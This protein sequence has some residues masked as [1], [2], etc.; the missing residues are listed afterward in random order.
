PLVRGEPAHFPALLEPIL[1][2]PFWLAGD[3]ELAYRLTQGL[4]ALAMSL[5]AVPV[6]L[7]ARTL[8]LG[9]GASLGCA[10]IAVAAPGVAYSAYILS[11]PIGYPLALTA[12]YAGVRALSRPT[13]GAQLAFLAGAG[14]ATLAR[15]QYAALLAAFV[16]A[17]IALER[18][19]AFRR[20]RVS[21]GLLL[22]PIAALA[23]L[24]PGALLGM[25]SGF[26]DGRIG[27]GGVASW[28]RADAML[29]A[30]ATGWILVPAAAI[31]FGAALVRPRMRAEQAFAWLVVPLAGALL[32]AAA[33]VADLGA[34]RFQERY[35]IALAPL[36]ALAAATSWRRGRMALRASAALALLLLVLAVRF[37]ISTYT[38]G[39]AI[40]D[41]PTLWAVRYLEHALGTADGA[42]VVALA[43]SVLS[44]LAAAAALNPRRL[45]P[46]V[47][48]AAVLS[49]V[50]LSA[51]AHAT[52][53]A[54][55]KDV[56]DRTFP[57]GKDWIDRSGLGEVALLQPPASSRQEA[58]IH[59]FW[60]P[61]V[62]EVLV[63]PEG[64]S[65]DHFAVT[66]VDLDPAGR[67]VADGRRVEKP[68]LI[69]ESR[70]R[71]E[72]DGAKHMAEAGSFTLWQPG[73]SFRFTMLAT[74]FY[75]D[76]WLAPKGTVRLWPDA[77]GRTSGTLLLTLSSLPRHFGVTTE[78]RLSAPGLE[79]RVALPLGA[80]R[81]LRIPVD[82]AGPF[83]L[84]F[85]ASSSIV[86]G[87]RSIAAGAPRLE[88]VRRSTA[89]V[90][91]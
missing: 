46:T 57:N 17:A 89:R 81:R 38:V 77:S 64:R 6:Y 31:G 39:A 72:L 19:R 80:L 90:V 84:H 70:T 52:D 40:S 43:A 53:R 1:A 55:S 58:L 75:H 47:L 78:I 7:L 33:A 87:G 9:P 32:L 68:L 49:C 42:L 59:L 60:N 66:R 67:L 36:T 83:V 14:L 79:G 88:F 18:G 82:T 29:L 62:D 74:G 12:V 30:Y 16:L 24:G 3:P 85:V 45:A 22:V 50:A 69:D 63:F 48:G 11:D 54:N 86:S 10:A 21:F 4:H 37:P 71:V 20:F 65:P 76:G 2:A 28:L 13:A 23:A 15:I 25:Y 44:L 26:G 41:S 56:S 73:P 34:E 51:G 8:R 27:P 91:R 35:L 61:S 5:A